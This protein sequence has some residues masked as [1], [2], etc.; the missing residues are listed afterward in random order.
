MIELA[1]HLGAGIGVFGLGFAFG[2]MRARVRIEAMRERFRA[3]MKALDS[4]WRG[5]QRA[6]AEAETP[7]A[8]AAAALRRADN[9]DL[10]W[11][12]GGD[13]SGGSER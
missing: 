1:L 9:P 5:Y 8:R 2:V 6:R 3:Q 13:R 7:A 10:G 11:P 12:Q 4:A